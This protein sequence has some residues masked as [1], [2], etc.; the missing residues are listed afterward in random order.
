MKDDLPDL[1]PYLSKKGGNNPARGGAPAQKADISQKLSALVKKPG[2][3]SVSGVPAVPAI[4]VETH[5]ESDEVIEEV[6]R[7]SGNGHPPA[8]QI[9][10]MSGEPAASP[11]EIPSQY[12]L[13]NS[14]SSWSAAVS[15]GT[16]A[17]NQSYPSGDD[18]LEPFDDARTSLAPPAV[19]APE[20]VIEHS[21][22]APINQVRHVTSERPKPV[23]PS[24]PADKFRAPQTKP[25]NTLSS[26]GNPPLLKTP[27]KAPG[28]APQPYS[29]RDEGPGEGVAPK[30][31][32]LSNPVKSTLPQ[33]SAL[34]PNAPAAPMGTGNVPARPATPANP[35]S[36][37]V[38]PPRPTP[39]PAP[40]PAPAPE[41]AP[42][43]APSPAPAPAPAKPS[44]RQN[45]AS[46]LF[47][48]DLDTVAPK[49]SA[50]PDKDALA[51]AF[52]EESG[53]VESASA[54]KDALARA[55][56]EESQALS[57]KSE[58]A[59]A[60]SSADYY[61]D[62]E[63]PRSLGFGSLLGSGDSS[64][65][66]QRT[67]L[68]DLMTPT[69]QQSTQFAAERQTDETTFDEPQ[70][71][72]SGESFREVGAAPPSFSSLFST[73]IV[74]P[75]EAAAAAPVVIDNSDFNTPVPQNFNDDEGFGKFIPPADTS[76]G[77]NSDTFESESSVLAG[78]L[79]PWQM[80]LQNPESKAQEVEEPAPY[81]SS[82]ILE[83]P[84]MAQI[85]DQVEQETYGNSFAP[86]QESALEDL[87][88]LAPAKDEA[89][90]SKSIVISKLLEA[91]NKSKEEEQSQA[92]PAEPEAKVQESAPASMGE[93]S[94]KAGEAD[95]VARILAELD[96]P[97]VDDHEVSLDELK[98]L[99]KKEKQEKK[100]AA[101]KAKEAEEALAKSSSEAV[102]K[103]DDSDADKKTVDPSDYDIP[104]AQKLAEAARKKAESEAPK[105]GGLA[106]LLSE[107]E[108]SPAPEP[109]AKAESKSLSSLL[110]KSSE[111]D[112]DDERESSLGDAVGAALDKLLA[113]VDNDK[114]ASEI[115]PQQAESTTNV[116]GGLNKLNFS[117]PEAEEILEQKIAASASAPEEDIKTD[118]MTMTQS[119]VDALSRLLEVAS[120]APEKSDEEGKKP[121]DSASKLAEMINKPPTKVSRQSMESVEARPQDAGGAY[122]GST[123]FTSPF[124]APSN[125][126]T[127]YPSQSSNM[128]GGTGIPSAPISGDAVSARIAALNRKL[129]EQSKPP[130]YSQASLPA[131]APAQQFSDNNT[132]SGSPYVP[133]QSTTNGGFNPAASSA[134]LPQS[135]PP[136][137]D[138]D[139]VGSKSELVSR[140]LGQAKLGQSNTDPHGRAPGAEPVSIEQVQQMRN[141]KTK[142]QKVKNPRE[143]VTNKS[144]SRSGPGVN[145]AVIL[146]ALVVVL[147]V[148]GGG[149][150][151]AVTNGII[152]MGKFKGVI[153]PDKISGL[154]ADKQTVDQHIKAGEFA[155]ARE[156]LEAK[157]KS[158]KLTSAELEKL[159]GVY[160]SLAE[161]M[162]TDG[163]DNTDAVKLLEKIPSKS[164]KHKDAQKLLRKLKKKVKKN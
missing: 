27:T 72:D 110:D 93:L 164:K 113:D 83:D 33:T 92:A 70:S 71:T 94:A 47:D 121:R 63:A 24:L 160:Y 123:P 102:S 17:T 49:S 84:G 96:T 42:A 142:Q 53:A 128:G 148:V 64:D 112:E 6:K 16:P 89:R 59:S 95:E 91:V 10:A 44:P 87:S 156:M 162:S 41:P 20:P 82:S 99:L 11:M 119:K 122:G 143:T 115:K 81:S 88:P 21:S 157:Q 134:S 46:S 149:G 48:D 100:E 60:P 151:F 133:S 4:D 146:G 68:T 153:N 118:P 161:D 107:S 1:T 106:S 101:R 57:Q 28:R 39:A 2:T 117:K 26:G 150:Y 50:Q 77:D 31:V 109:V 86:P 104:I 65:V 137:S 120:K 12:N 14:N 135:P 37:P 43:P 108:E 145:P 15:Q 138:F 75:L 116:V 34:R 9:P 163:T 32:P 111:E 79:E 38:T 36:P 35:V 29:Y 141:N 125:S 56:M 158:S 19:S 103:A 8:M 132:F 66:S 40:A 62:D 105:K 80:A 131:Q 3:S 73:E 5:D 154:M 98:A 51:R 25:L 69:G 129:E 147:L 55:F 45:L 76:G 97:R 139:E 85:E 18:E 22:D 58:S 74:A 61:S 114:G 159:Y 13:G 78:Q 30:A 140:I 67:A 127:N 152:D 155:R 126:M 144:R 136:L 7:E 130:S 54:D 124:S 90:Q 23:T 52:R